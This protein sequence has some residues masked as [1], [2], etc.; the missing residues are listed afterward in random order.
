LHDDGVDLYRGQF[1]RELRPP[2]SDTFRKSQFDNQVLPF[3]IPVI[4]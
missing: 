1:L 2:F 4:T 3:D